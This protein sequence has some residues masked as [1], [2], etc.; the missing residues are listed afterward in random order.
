MRAGRLPRPRGRDCGHC[1]RRDGGN[2][3]ASI[4]GHGRRT[5]V[6]KRGVPQCLSSTVLSFDDTHLATVTHP[7]GPVAAALFAFCEKQAVSGED[8][9][10]ALALGI[11]IECRMS[12]V[13]LLPPARANLGLFVTGI[14]GPIDAAVALGKLLRLDEQRNA[15]GARP[16]RGAGRGLPRDA[17]RDGGAF[18]IPAHAARNGVTAA[19]LAAG[20]VVVHGQCAGSAEGLRRRLRQQAA[21]STAPSTAAWAGTSS[22]WRMPTSR[23]PR[24]SSR[25]RRSTPVSRSRASSPLTRHS[26]L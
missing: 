14:T 3:Q 26:R 1:R 4:I 17:W 10:T 5:H 12:N 7:T 20:G 13:L 22:C 19:M 15:L 16:R 24:A 11:E 18:F 2:P 21:I 6:A 9:V 25:I 23:I 8:F